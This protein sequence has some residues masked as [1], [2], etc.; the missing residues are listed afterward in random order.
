MCVEGSAAMAGV[1]PLAPRGAPNQAVFHHARMEGC[2]SGLNYVCV[3][4]GPRAK[5]VRSQTPRTLLHQP[6]E[7]KVLGLLPP[8]SLLSK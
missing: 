6:L 4:Q 8:G 5:P 2:V 1:R 3:N 7:G